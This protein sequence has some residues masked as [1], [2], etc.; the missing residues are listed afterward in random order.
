MTPCGLLIIDVPAQFA[1]YVVRVIH[2][3]YDEY[4]GSN[5]L[6]NISDYLRIYWSTHWRS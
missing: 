3:D 1:A 2:K 4:G 5:L 6:L